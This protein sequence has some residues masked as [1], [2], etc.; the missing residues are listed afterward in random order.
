MIDKI[1]EVLKDYE[2]EMEGYSYYGSNPGVSCE[3]YREM[4]DKINGLI[5]TQLAL[6]QKEIDLLEPCVKFYSNKGNYSITSSFVGCLEHER[7]LADLDG[8]KEP[9]TERYAGKLAR[10]TMK[11]L[12]KMRG[13]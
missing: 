5:K 6:K 1:V 11:E 2:Q 3:D 13:E 7:I 9:N 8:V 4:A 10:S 12:L